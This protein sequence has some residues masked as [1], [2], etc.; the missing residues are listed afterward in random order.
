MT[1]SNAIVLKCS[2][3][4]TNNMNFATFLFLPHFDVICDVLL[5]VL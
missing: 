5:N 3:I 4:V 2:L 1:V